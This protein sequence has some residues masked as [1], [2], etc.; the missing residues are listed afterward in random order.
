MGRKKW[1]KEPVQLLNN[2]RGK[3]GAEL[4]FLGEKNKKPNVVLIRSRSVS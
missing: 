3:I 2:K 1:T 4:E